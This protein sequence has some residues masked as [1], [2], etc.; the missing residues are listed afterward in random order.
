MRAYGPAP[1][2]SRLFCQSGTKT[3]SEIPHAR[4]SD[5][6]AG[7]ANRTSE[8]N[9]QSWK[10]T[11]TQSVINPG[12]SQLHCSRVS[13]VL[14]TLVPIAPIAAFV[15]PFRANSSQPSLKS[16]STANRIGSCHQTQVLQS[17]YE[18]EATHRD[19]VQV[20]GS[21]QSCWQF[22]FQRQR[23][24]RRIMRHEEQVWPRS[25][26]LLQKGRDGRAVDLVERASGTLG[27]NPH[28]PAYISW[29]PNRDSGAELSCRP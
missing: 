11:W 20:G 3:L 14:K 27:L 10:E 5:P 18:Y 25:K 29:K 13:R 7:H 16:V 12:E 2:L 21:T 1:A 8:N 19:G 15:T 4:N 6:R 17:R 26:S 28:P 9:S 24:P 22:G 23:R